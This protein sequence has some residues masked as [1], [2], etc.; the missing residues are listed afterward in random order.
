M[1][2]QKAEKKL[3]S[4]VKSDLVNKLIKDR[5]GIEN[6]SES[7]VIEQTILDSFLPVRKSARDIIENYLYCDGGNI[8][9][10]LAALFGNNA[11]GTNW[12]SRY[13]NF[14][15]LVQFAKS[16]EALSGTTLCGKEDELHHCCSQ[17]ESVVDKLER[18][19]ESDT[20]HKISYLNEADFGKHLL[21]E[22]REEPENSHLI[23][24]YAL[25]IN[26]WGD[27][28]GWS[29]TYRLLMDLAR[30]G[31]YRNNDCASRTELLDIV[32]RISAEW[33]E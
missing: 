14:L 7:S 2:R 24:L 29:I 15:S 18:L 31:N 16:Q 13:D 30:L 10:T 6:R 11:A 8:A 17:L 12:N 1:A 9:D 28:K 22:L 5:A 19:A 21:L 4:F 23:N 33:D 20:E 26:N 3:I 32:N 27:L 25:I